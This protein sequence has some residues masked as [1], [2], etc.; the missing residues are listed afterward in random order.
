MD[1]NL[2]KQVLSLPLSQRL[3]LVDELWD[4]IYAE[5]DDIPITEELRA[6]IDRRL[7]RYKADPTTAKPWDEVRKRL[8][9]E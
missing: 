1:A 4:S 3:E 7:A 9:D 8:W 6:E 5:A 2:T